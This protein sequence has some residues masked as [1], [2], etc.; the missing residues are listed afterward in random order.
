MNNCIQKHHIF[1]KYMH[2]CFLANCRFTKITVC[3]LCF[4][5]TVTNLYSNI[6]VCLFA[7]LCIFK[8]AYLTKLLYLFQ[9]KILN[10]FF[11]SSAFDPFGSGPTPAPKPQDFMGAFLGPGNM[12]QPDPFLHAARSPSPT[13]QNMGMGKACAFASLYCQ[14]VGNITITTSKALLCSNPPEYYNQNSLADSSLTTALL[15][16]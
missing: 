3:C 12:G 7:H 10:A 16:I 14:C 11:N 1:L 13:M 5:S 15:L 6:E 4:P 8:C 2:M 9:P